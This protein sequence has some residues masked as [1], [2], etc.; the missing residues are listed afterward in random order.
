MS[1][2]GARVSFIVPVFNAIGFLPVATDSIRAAAECYGNADITLVDNGSTDGSW[3]WMSRELAEVATLV[4]YPGHTVAGL[5]NEGARLAGGAVLAFVDAD[6]VLPPDY[7]ERA[8][9]VLDQTG[10]SGTGSRYQLPPS[11]HWIEFTWHELH[12]RPQ[13]GPVNYINSGNLCLRRDAFEAVGGFNASLLTGEDAE[14]GQRLKRA[15]LPLYESASV[16]AIHLGN[17]KSLGHFFRKQRWHA[18]GMFGT[19]DLHSI[20]RPTVMMSLQLAALVAAPV[21]LVVL[22]LSGPGRVMVAVGVLFAIPALTVGFRLATG[23]RTRR[24]IA[25]VGLYFVYYVA[26]LVALVDLGWRR[27]NR[28]DVSR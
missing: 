14:L 20:D 10:A 5:R 7:V 12:D 2:R 19:V 9:A 24:P 22:P 8:L 18:L 21:L 16:P 1:L 11:P 28:L 3:E 4:R 6:C 17:P 25:A 27:V 13:E 15:G 23:G 26:R